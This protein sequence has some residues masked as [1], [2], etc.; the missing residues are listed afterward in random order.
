MSPEQAAG[1]ADQIDTRTDV[2]SLGVILYRLLTGKPP[3][4]VHGSTFDI[5]Q[6]LVNDEIAPPVPGRP[7]GGPGAGSDPLQVAGEGPG[8]A[9]RLGRWRCRASWAATSTASRSTPARTPCRT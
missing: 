5:L 6:R 3:H 7:D 9:L 4:P 8:P 1:D 2:Y